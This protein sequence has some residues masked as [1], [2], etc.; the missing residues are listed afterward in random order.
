MMN[1]PNLQAIPLPAMLLPGTRR[2]NHAAVELSLDLS[3]STR[4]LIQLGL[5]SL[6]FD[7]G[8]VDGLF[9]NR[10]RAAIRSWQSENDHQATGHLTRLQA[11]ALLA[12]GRDAE[13]KRAAERE[14]TGTAPHCAATRGA[15]E[16]GTATS[17]G[18][19]RGGAAEGNSDKM[20]ENTGAGGSGGALGMSLGEVFRDCPRLPGNGGGAVRV[21]QDGRAC[22]GNRP[23][24]Q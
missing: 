7:A 21:F 17:R 14:R 16:S 3:R 18:K 9:G 2:N 8:P 15:T 22:R 5:T 10:T 1:E 4:A 11:D 23:S 6:G 20:E 13:Q 12:A 24:R 19:S